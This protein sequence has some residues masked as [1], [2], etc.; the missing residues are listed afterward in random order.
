MR[1]PIILIFDS[2]IGGLSVYEHIKQK[3]PNADYVYLFDDEGF[4][5][6]DKTE[7]F[8]I[9]RLQLI[10]QSAI[11]RYH[12][13]I[14]VIACNT[15]STVCLSHLREQFSVPFIGVV[16][17]IKPAAKLSKNGVIGL[18]ATKG[19]IKRAYTQRLVD[20]YAS[21][22]KIEY[23]GLSELVF[24][25]E[26][27]LQGVP[28]DMNLLRELMS[29]WLSL[30]HMPDTI[31]LGCTHYPFIKPELMQLFPNANF[32]DSGDAISNR[33]SVVLDSLILDKKQECSSGSILV[34]TK[35][36][37]SNHNKLLRN[38]SFSYQQHLFIG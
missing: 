10:M 23:L 7:L 33:V 24:I 6:G 34:N 4:P 22:L 38:F 21:N 25:A 37:S 20:D 17:A 15:A 5:Y 16:P 31:I 2:G 1:N 12:P 35:I 3:L 13:D 11:E 9:E 27:K 8:L 29:P 26:D 30:E 36:E 19:T 14:I 32:V 18:L 28:V